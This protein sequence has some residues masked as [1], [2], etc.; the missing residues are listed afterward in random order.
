MLNT[1]VFLCYLA[2]KARQRANGEWYIPYEK[3][4][5]WARYRLLKGVT[6]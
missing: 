2:Y 3:Y 5:A 1:E 6:V 4:A